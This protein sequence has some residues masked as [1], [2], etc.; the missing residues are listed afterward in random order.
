MKILRCPNN[1]FQVKQT[2]VLQSPLIIFLIFSFYNIQ[3]NKPIAWQGS[4]IKMPHC[5][6][7]ITPSAP[8]GALL[9][10]VKMPFQELPKSIRR[11]QGEAIIFFGR[12]IAT[13]VGMAGSFYSTSSSSLAMETWLHFRL[14][15][16]IFK[17]PRLLCWLLEKCLR[18][19]R[20]PHSPEFPTKKQVRT[21]K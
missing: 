3:E 2:T 18:K 13:V 1:N 16:D 8:Q 17:G 15:S 19:L 6:I 7:I 10:A 12:E 4:S 9:S 5:Y 11:T 14:V 21:A 20:Q